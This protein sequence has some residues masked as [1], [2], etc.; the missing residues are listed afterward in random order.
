MKVTLAQIKNSE[1]VLAKL[2]NAEL[3][4]QVSFRLSKL[5]KRINEEL[6]EFESSRQKLFEKYGEQQA[7]STIKIKDE[8]QKEFLSQINALL[9]EQIELPDVKVSISEISDL[10]FSAIEMAALEPWITE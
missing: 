6:V 3:P 1:I 7:D 5:I 2:L 9:G 8:F 4:I 10:K